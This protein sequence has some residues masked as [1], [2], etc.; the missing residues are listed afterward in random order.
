MAR[1]GK[2][3]VTKA[4]GVTVAVGG[5]LGVAVVDLVPLA[6]E[7]GDGLPLAVRLP[8][9]V[10]L[11]ERDGEGVT[12]PVAV[13]VPLTV[14]DA[15]CD[16]D[17]VADG[18]PERLA[19]ALWLPVALP[20]VLGVWVCE[21]DAEA[22]RDTLAEGVA[23]AGAVSLAEAPTERACVPVPVAAPVALPV[24]VAVGVSVPELLLLGVAVAEPVAGAVRVGV[25]VGSRMH[26]RTSRTASASMLDGRTPIVIVCAPLCWKTRVQLTQPVLLPSTR[27]AADAFH[28]T[29]LLATPP[30]VTSSSVTHAAPSTK[31]A[32]TSSDTSIS[33]AENTLPADAE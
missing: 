23:V 8:L 29:K 19:V 28:S 11:G 7:K 30:R 6:V 15:V 26:T 27:P 24:P 22:V 5:L 14:C 21:R 10:P 33:V 32:R 4:S 12:E 16:S 3:C 25:G 20:V 2:R 13:L 1:G 17:A 18:L 31:A 9:A